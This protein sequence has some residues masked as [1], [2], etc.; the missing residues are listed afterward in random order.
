MHEA[1][2]SPRRSLRE[3]PRALTLIHCRGG[4][5]RAE[6]ELSRFVEDLAQESDHKIGAVPGDP[7]KQPFLPAMTL[8]VR[9]EPLLHYHFAPTGHETAPFRELI[10]KLSSEPDPGDSGTG[11]RRTGGRLAQVLLFVSAQCPNCPHVVRGVTAL[12]LNKQSF[13]LHILDV[14]QHSNLAASHRV[15]SVPT[16]LVDEVPFIGLFDSD[17]MLR[18][19]ERK[20]RTLALQEQVLCL[21]EDGHLSEAGLLLAGG[22]DPSFLAA[23]FGG[24][25]FNRKLSLLA[26]CEEAMEADPRCLDRMAEKL[27]P[28]LDSHDS[29]LR[30]DIADLLGKI[31]NPIAQ[32]ALARL[33][34]DPDPEVAEAAREAAHRI[35][36]RPT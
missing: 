31:G 21:L 32:E 27:L 29:A 15:R 30:G 24:A 3:L 22:V 10:W 26:I 36:T 12:A 13:S 33:F 5:E 19:L 20:E 1:R 23:H 14:T 4:P 35:S 8:C 34:R 6:L 25:S 16:A 28:F 18:I 7:V 11:K 2:H 17:R 9:G